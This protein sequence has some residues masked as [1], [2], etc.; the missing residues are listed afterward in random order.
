MRKHPSGEGHYARRR[1]LGTQFGFAP[2]PYRQYYG[3]SIFGAPF[4]GW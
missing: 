2:Q 4:S 1:D 3:R